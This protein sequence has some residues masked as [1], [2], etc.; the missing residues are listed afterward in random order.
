MIDPEPISTALW[1]S[2][3]R[4]VLYGRRR[5]MGAAKLPISLIIWGG[6]VA[7]MLSSITMVTLGAR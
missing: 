6:L 3:A 5:S 2:P 7:A 4:S 1:N